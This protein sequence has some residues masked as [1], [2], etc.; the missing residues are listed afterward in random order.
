MRKL[1]LNLRDP[2]NILTARYGRQSFPKASPVNHEVAMRSKKPNQLLSSGNLRPLPQSSLGLER[3]WLL[4]QRDH[5]Y[6][7]RVM[8]VRVR[9]GLKTPI[10]WDDTQMLQILRHEEAAAGACKY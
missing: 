7:C 1:L 6:Y 10:Q 3:T 8:V 2:F 4:K 9:L 5:S